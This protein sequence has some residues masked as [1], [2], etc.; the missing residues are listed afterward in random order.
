VICTENNIPGKAIDNYIGG[1]EVQRNYI[2]K[3]IVQNYK[4]GVRQ[5][6]IYGIGNDDTYAD[7]TNPWHVMGLYQKL[8]NIGPIT[9]GGIYNQQYTDEGIANKTTSNILTGLNYDAQTT[10]AMALPANIDGAAFKNGAGNYVYVLWA[11]TSID[12]SEAATAVY[13]FPAAVNVTPTLYKKDWNFFVTQTT[14]TISSSNI[15]LTGSPVFLSS[16]FTILPYHRDTIIRPIIPNVLS[17]S[18]YP[19]PAHDVVAAKFSIKQKVQVSMH[20]FNANGQM[21]WMAIPAKQLAAGQYTIPLSIP[22]ALNAGMYYCKIY[23]NEKVVIEKLI[24]NK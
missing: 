1:A 11:K 7:A 16:N 14:S 20:V 2:I 22:S 13:N 8:I 21:V 15:A 17:W 6:Y 19:N 23:F 12:N 10:T 4:M 3:S 18:L 5:M 9:N 24:I